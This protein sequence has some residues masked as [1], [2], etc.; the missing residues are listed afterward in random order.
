ME[1]KQIEQ[2]KD[3]YLNKNQE[4]ENMIQQVMESDGD[5]TAV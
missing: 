1:N 5:A 3:Y 4:I 2:A